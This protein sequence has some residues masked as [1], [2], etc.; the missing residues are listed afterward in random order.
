MD[1]KASGSNILHAMPHQIFISYAHDN[2]ISDRGD[3]KGWVSALVGYLIARLPGK[4]GKRRSIFG[5][6]TSLRGT[7]R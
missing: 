2:D 1:K 3:D 7:N 5:K 4:I 6:M